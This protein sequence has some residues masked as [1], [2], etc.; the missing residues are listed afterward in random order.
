MPKPRRT[1][2]RTLAREPMMGGD[3][4]DGPDSVASQY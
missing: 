2:T 3:R 1:F 4:P